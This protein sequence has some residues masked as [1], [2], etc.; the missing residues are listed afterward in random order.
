MPHQ[1]QLDLL[2]ALSVL[3]LGD[4]LAAARIRPG[5]RKSAPARRPR[6]ANAGSSASNRLPMPA[7]CEPLTGIHEHRARPARHPRAGRP[8]RRRVLTG[9]QR[10]QTR[11]RLGAITGHHGGELGLPGPVMI[12]GVGHIG[13][14][15]LRPAPCIQSANTDA[16]DRHPRRRLTRHHQRRHRRLR[17]V[18][19]GAARRLGACSITTCAFVPP[20]PNDDTPARRGRPVSGQSVCCATTFSRRLSNGMCGFGLSKCRFGGISPRCTASTALMKPAI[21]AAASRWPRFVLTRADQQRRVLGTATT[22]HRAQ[23]AR[24]DRIAQQRSGAVGLDVVDHAAAASP[25]WRTRHAAPPSGL[26]GWEPS[27]RWSGRP[28]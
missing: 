3:P 20:N 1:H 10:A 26:P 4:H 27:A 21:P 24:F 9:R 15:H 19:D 13:Q 6:P 7:H 12:E 11:H 28:G 22:Q 8:R 2:D 5:Q 14:R 23:R 25:R 16:V 17:A 18:S